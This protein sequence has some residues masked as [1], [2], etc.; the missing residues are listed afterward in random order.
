MATI[1]QYKDR[2]K[3]DK[4]VITDLVKQNDLLKLEV[5]TTRITNKRLRTEI[6]KLTK[7]H[8][9]QFWK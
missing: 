8:W 4:K 6:D 1:Q 5:S 7:K 3:R 9:W 2:A